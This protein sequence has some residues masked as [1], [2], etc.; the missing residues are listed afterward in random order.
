MRVITFKADPELVLLIEEYARRHNVTKSEIIRRALRDYLSK[1][2][3]KPFRT[4]RIIIY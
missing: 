2:K 1:G 3:E 4:A